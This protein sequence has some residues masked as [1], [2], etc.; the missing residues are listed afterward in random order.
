MNLYASVFKNSRVVSVRRQGGSGSS[1]PGTVAS[2]TF[3]IDGQ[4]FYVLN[5][6][7]TV[8]FTPT[9]SFFVSC[10][11]QEEVDHLWENLSVGGSKMQC[12]WIRDRFGISWQIVPS[13]LGELLGDA[14]AAKS[15]R[16]WNAMLQMHKL[17]IQNSRKLP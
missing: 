12:G 5:G 13:V 2:G 8:A 14:D 9:I 17:E 16:V 6:G 3:E 15:G 4:T 10:E 1:E 11:S 7:P